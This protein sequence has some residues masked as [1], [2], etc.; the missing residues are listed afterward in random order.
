[1][2]KK[3]L[4]DYR[5]LQEFC[6][7]MWGR[8]LNFLE[9]IL[10]NNCLLL[11]TG[12]LVFLQGKEAGAIACCLARIA[13]FFGSGVNGFFLACVCMMYAC[14]ALRCHVTCQAK[15]FIKMINITSALRCS[16]YKGM[17]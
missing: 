7:S 12:Y 3:S 9:G 10:A 1:M 13:F 14:S 11:I 17:M 15:L 8:L 4:P 2:A 5:R 6:S 16:C